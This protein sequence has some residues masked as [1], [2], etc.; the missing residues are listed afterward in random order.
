[1]GNKG[2]IV[3]G[4]NTSV[5]YVNMNSGSMGNPMQGMVRIY[6]SDMQVFDGS[7]WINLAASYATVE[8]DAETQRLLEYV[9]RQEKEELEI[10]ALISG[11][12]HPA[13]RIAQENLNKANE[14]LIRAK[15]QLKATVIL[16][17]EH[18]IN[19]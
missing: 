9:R 16:S 19:E 14:E 10:K 1:M 12:H 8:L 4:G 11:H 6:G 18:E 13:V 5:P 2:V 7:N 3:S 17:K 15:Q